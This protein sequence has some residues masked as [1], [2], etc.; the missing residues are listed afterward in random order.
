MVYSSG[1][2]AEG[3]A[4]PAN[5]LGGTS[6]NDTIY[7]TSNSDTIS[8]GAG[9]DVI[10]GG[11]AADLID[12]GKGDDVVVWNPGGSSDTLDGGAGVDTLQ[13][14]QANVSEAISLTAAGRH[15]ILTRD[16]ATIRMDLNNLERIVFGAAGGSGGND[17]YVIG[18]LSGTDI[19]SVEVD[20]GGSYDVPDGVADSVSAVGTAGRDLLSVRTVGA[21]TTLTGLPLALSIRDGELIDRLAVDAGLGDDRLDLSGLN[22]MTAAFNGGAGNDAVAINGG[23]QADA[24][25]LFGSQP[26]ADGDPLGFGMNGS[27]AQAYLLGVEMVSVAGGG[28]NDVIQASSLAIATPLLLD[29]GSGDDRIFG[30][31]AAETV[32]G[33]AGNDVLD[34]GFGGDVVRGGDGDDTF[35]WNPG[36]GSDTIAGGYGVDGVVFNTS[37]I[38][39]VIGVSAL[40]GHAIVT[41]NIANISLDVDDVEQLSF[42]GTGGGA[43]RFTLGDL[44]ATDVKR[45]DIDLAGSQGADGLTDVVEISGGLAGES[46]ELITTGA[47]T[48][49]KGL[50]AAINILGA[51]A[52]DRIDISGGLGN[53]TIDASALAGGLSIT[54]SGAAGNDS[55]RGGHENDILAGGT[56]DDTMVGSDGSDQFVFDPSLGGNDQV[57]DFQAHGASLEGDYI[58]LTNFADASFDAAVLNGHIVQ[59]GAD[60]LVADGS[61]IHITLKNVSLASLQA[62]DFLFF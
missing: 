45:I 15:A 57:L 44:S 3:F 13:F 7:G 23:D 17:T 54:L 56:G 36:G 1:G 47:L 2:S 49:V 14:N 53:D 48:E 42:G 26:T 43:D 51:E 46:I 33:G 39:E 5:A 31:A 41:R 55:L 58:V 37:S 8:A 25:L 34:G 22:N 21:L 24:I 10:D 9:N 16:I 11:F 40:N 27:S 62:G 61:A 29:G 35:L 30:S 52:V 18:D 50:A 19:R 38:G 32:E 4:V 60:V 6:G 59:V 28:G 12:A 20:L